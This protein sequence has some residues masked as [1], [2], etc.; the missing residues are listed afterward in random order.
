MKRLILSLMVI[1]LLS[2][3]GYAKSVEQTICW[4]KND[5]AKNYPYSVATIGDNT[6][7]CSGKCNGKTIAQ[8]NKKGWKLT[9]VIGGLQGSFGMVMT[10]ER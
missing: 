3:N 5:C 10:K 8:M 6:K 1:G 7:L 9:E 4:S 2:S